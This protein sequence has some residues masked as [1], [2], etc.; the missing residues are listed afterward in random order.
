M[1]SVHTL[2]SECTTDTTQQ[3]V[4]LCLPP[5]RVVDCLSCRESISTHPLRRSLL[6]CRPA[7]SSVLRT[8]KNGVRNTAL[9]EGGRTKKACGKLDVASCDKEPTGRPGN[10][11]CCRWFDYVEAITVLHALLVTSPVQ[12][13]QSQMGYLRRLKQAVC[14]QETQRR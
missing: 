14:C 13:H 11:R 10:D 1:D 9:L 5:G 2:A 7:C 4:A 3:E 12:E 6:L 8:G